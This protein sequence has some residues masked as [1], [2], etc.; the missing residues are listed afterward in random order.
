MLLFIVA[1]TLY[2]GVYMFI[3]FIIYLE[4][5]LVLSDS[6]LFTLKTHYIQEYHRIFKLKATQNLYK[7]HQ[8]TELDSHILL[9][10]QLPKCCLPHCTSINVNPLRYHLGIHLVKGRLIL[11]KQWLTGFPPYSWYLTIKRRDNRDNLFQ[12]VIL[13]NVGDSANTVSPG[14]DY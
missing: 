9:K 14:V 8:T 12:A 3:L 13:V 5:V 1:S 2:E 4:K 6:M 10:S 11:G 7:N